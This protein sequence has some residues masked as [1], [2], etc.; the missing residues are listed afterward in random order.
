MEGVDHSA[1]VFRKSSYSESGNCVEVGVHRES[2]LI[3]D[4]K[5]P[6]GGI[7]SVSPEAWE[8][9]INGVRDGSSH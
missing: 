4:S 3:R 6:N 5:C 2:V 7:I 1:V 9:F 8:K